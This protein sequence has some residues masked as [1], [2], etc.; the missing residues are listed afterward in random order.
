MLNFIK[1]SCKDDSNISSMRILNYLTLGG[2]LCPY[3][4]AN[5]SNI[6][7]AIMAKTPVVFIDIPVVAA[8]IVTAIITAKVIQAATAERK[9]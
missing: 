6:V 9:P 1:D 2:V 4:M 8:G 3:V 7:T 5:L